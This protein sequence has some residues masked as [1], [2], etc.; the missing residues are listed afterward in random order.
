MWALSPGN[1]ILAQSDP[2]AD[3]SDTGENEVEESNSA[4]QARLTERLY[5]RKLLSGVSTAS[6]VPS[7]MG[8]PCSPQVGCRIRKR[9]QHA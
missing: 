9:A 5:G 8:G 1:R 6:R 3:S 4:M 7:L 2:D